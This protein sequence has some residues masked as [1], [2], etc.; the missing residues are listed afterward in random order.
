MEQDY[1]RLDTVLAK[2]WDQGVDGLRLVL[3]GQTRN[4]GA[5]NYLGVASRVIP[6]NATLI[7]W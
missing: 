4:T 7:P 3:E 1:Y 6:M 2:L 5:G